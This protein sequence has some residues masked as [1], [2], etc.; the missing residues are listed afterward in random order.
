MSEQLPIPIRIDARLQWMVT[1]TRSGMLVGVCDPLGLVI[2]GTDEYD[3]SQ[4]IQE[5]LQLMMNDLL[6]SG[7]L[8]GFLRSRGWQALGI[9][10]QPTSARVP[11]EV[12][13]ELIQ[14]QAQQN[15][16]TRAA[17]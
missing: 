10:R 17:H 8:H 2:Q 3:L 11:F 14:Q 9:P 4:N 15:G 1:K 12:P 7:E 13:F 16:P 5:S 6:R